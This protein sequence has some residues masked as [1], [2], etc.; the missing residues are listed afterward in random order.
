LLFFTVDFDAAVEELCAC[1]VAGAAAGLAA[2]CAANVKGSEAAIR[3]MVSKV[4]FIF[5]SQ[6]AFSLSPAH[7]PMLRFCA[8]DSDSL[9][10]LY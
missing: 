2:V 4:V 10:R 5:F 8:P 3:A 7:N 6:R 9:R 1:V